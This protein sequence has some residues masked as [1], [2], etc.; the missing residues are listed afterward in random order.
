MNLPPKTFTWS[1]S[2][3]P[4][5]HC[6]KCTDFE[7]IGEVSSNLAYILGGSQSFIC[8][9]YR[10]VCVR[11]FQWNCS[12]QI[13]EESACQEFACFHKFTGLPVHN[14]E[15]RGCIILI[16]V[17]AVPPKS[18]EHFWSLSRRERL[19]WWLSM[20]ESKRTLSHFLDTHTRSS[21]FIDKHRILDSLLPDHQSCNHPWLFH[22]VR[23]SP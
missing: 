20:I 15:L 22:S 12:S 19:R 10:C 17:L 18:S 9:E 13:S 5:C 7:I 8:F 11:H 6:K 4:N 16:K 1:G 2:F 14:W 3:Q 21:S 23:W